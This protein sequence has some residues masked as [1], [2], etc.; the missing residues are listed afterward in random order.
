[1]ANPRGNPQNLTP[2]Q[3]G[4]V[5]MGGRPRRRPQSEAHDQRLR[6]PLDN[7]TRIKMKL[8]PGA[9]QA[10]AISWMLVE[11]AKRGSVLAAKELRESVEGK[12]TQRFEL[13]PVSERG[14]TV[15]VEYEALTPESAQRMERFQRDLDAK[16]LPQ[17]IDVE[18]ETPDT[19]E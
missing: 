8:A 18:P 19:S 16:S 13:N 5:G 11:K 4:H 17:T 10:D 12:S 6:A 3:P 14:W 15:N 1:M 2:F 7:E 9:T